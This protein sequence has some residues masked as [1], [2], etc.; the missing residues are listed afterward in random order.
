MT[1]DTIEELRAEFPGWT[2]D[3][4]KA[5]AESNLVIHAMRELKT[6]GFPYPPTA[7]N[8][9]N[10]DALMATN[11]LELIIR[12]SQQGHSGT[13]A[14]Y[15]MNRLDRLMGMRNI[16]PL[17]G[18][19]DEWVEVSEGWWQNLRNGEAFSWDGGKNYYL[20]SEQR[21]W[22]LRLTP[23][24]IRRRLSDRVWSQMLY[25]TRQPIRR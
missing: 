22:V 25:P 21:K 3:Q 23:R 1:T 9:I 2:A 12:F 4:Y 17:T 24:W 6:L 16:T 14:S 11:L 8:Q 10:I 5:A 19:P 7:A 15:L 13:S 18:D 20:L